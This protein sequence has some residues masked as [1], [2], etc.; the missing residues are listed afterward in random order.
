VGNSKWAAD[1]ALE[2][3]VD[4]LVRSHLNEKP[5]LSEEGI[6]NQALNYRVKIPRD[7]YLTEREIKITINKLLEEKMIILVDISNH[8]IWADDFPQTTT[9]KLSSLVKKNI[10][11]RW[12]PCPRH[13]PTEEQETVVTTKAE[14]I[15]IKKAQE[16]AY[17]REKQRQ[18]AAA[19]REKI[20]RQHWVYY[21]QWASDPGFVKIGYSTTPAER[22][23]SFLTGSPG[24][25]RL[26]RLEKVASQK[27]ES[28]RHWRFGAYHHRRE[29]FEYEGGLRDY[30]ESLDTEPG[31]K[32]WEQFSSKA[33]TE[34]DVDFF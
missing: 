22:V 18:E 11:R 3:V 30:I 10:T 28:E 6:I 5:Y 7:G 15:K 1:S 31:I 33:R 20:S 29:W 14:Q 8:S 9:Y 21:I 23:S 16:E 26:L 12:S 32:L 17:Q 27:D 19:F 13:H 2:A 4:V 24:R 25:L 34:I